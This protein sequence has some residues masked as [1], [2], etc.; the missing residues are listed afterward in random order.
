[1]N[2]Q[3]TRLEMLMVHFEIASILLH[4]LAVSFSSWG[5][6]MLTIVAWSNDGNRF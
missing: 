2:N 5:V 3:L 4:E 6:M 1:M